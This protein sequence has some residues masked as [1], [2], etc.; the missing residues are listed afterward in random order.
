MTT[1]TVYCPRS[2]GRALFHCRDCHRV[3]LIAYT[4]KTRK[5]GVKEQITEIAFNG[6]G[7]EG[8][9]GHKNSSA[10]SGR[11]S[12]LRRSGGIH[13]LNPVLYSAACISRVPLNSFSPL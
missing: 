3:F 10:L 8:Q 6:A 1:A 2:E 5:P 13:V 12:R 11:A 4:C 7:V 9:P